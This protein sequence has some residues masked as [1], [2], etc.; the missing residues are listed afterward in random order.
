MATFWVEIVKCD[1][2]G[3]WYYNHIGVSFEVTDRDGPFYDVIG[4]ELERKG[5]RL[6][7]MKNDT[8]ISE[9]A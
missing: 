4:G 8:K 6:I 2:E 7:I 3:R 9:I 5:E 1:Y